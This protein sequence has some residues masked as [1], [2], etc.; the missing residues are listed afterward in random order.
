M[1]ERMLR[2]ALMEA[3]LER[4]RDV[5]EGADRDWSWSAPVSPQ[6]DA[7]AG[8]PLRLGEADGPSG[9]EAGGPDGGLRGSGMPGDPGEPDGGEPRRPGRGAGVAAG[10]H[11]GTASSTRPGNRDGA[12]DPEPPDWML[13]D[14]PEGWALDS[15]SD[16]GGRAEAVPLRGEQRAV[17]C[18]YPPRPGRWLGRGDPESG[19]TAGK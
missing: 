15:A 13:T 11:G 2:L 18:S 1:D 4:F 7:A 16:L 8:G 17:F 3:N 19:R 6:P 5:L 9:V 12:E 10:D 14:L